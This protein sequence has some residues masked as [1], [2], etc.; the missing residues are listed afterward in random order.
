M[1]SC[2]SN[3]TTS[4]QSPKIF[5]NIQQIEVYKIAALAVEVNGYRV[6]LRLKSNRGLAWS[7]IFVEEQDPP[8]KLDEWKL[9]LKPF[10]GRF[11]FSELTKQLLQANSLKSVDQ[12]TIYLYTNAL[13]QLKFMPDPKK[14]TITQDED[15]LKKR[16]VDFFSI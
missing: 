7:E 8:V 3:D 15:V 1:S 4:L 9:A 5:I 10:V 12:R 16:A 11:E 13:H 2:P 6:C 14:L